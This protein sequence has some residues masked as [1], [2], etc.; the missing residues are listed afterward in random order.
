MAADRNIGKGESLQVR[1]RVIVSVMLGLLILLT[2]IAFGLDLLFPGRVGIRFVARSVFP[3]PI[4]TPNE[5]GQRM[6]AAARQRQ[7]LAGAGGRLPITDAMRQIAGRGDHA[8]DPV[9]P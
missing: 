6:A 2:L 7:A 9:G 3:A 1:A 8:F 4:V 5:R